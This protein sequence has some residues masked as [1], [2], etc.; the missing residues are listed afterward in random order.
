MGRH[1]RL[2]SYDASMHRLCLLIAVA[3]AA[4]T[5]GAQCDPCATTRQVTST[6]LKVRQAVKAGL[7][8]I[9]GRATVDGAPLPGLTV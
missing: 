4:T 5:V 6:E 7:P 2:C 3:F 8:V 9:W 1:P